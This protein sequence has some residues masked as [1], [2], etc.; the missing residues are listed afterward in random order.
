MNFKKYHEDWTDRIRPDILKRDKFKCQE[1]GAVH[2]GYYLVSNGRYAT[3][4]EADEYVEYTGHGVKCA[5]VYLQ[6]AHLDM[7]RNNND[8]SNLRALCLLCHLRF[9][10]A[11]KRLCR[12]AKKKDNCSSGSG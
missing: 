2:K 7:D 12:L 3:R 11:Y 6:V 5:R 1:C 10:K 4:I 8:Y 9:D